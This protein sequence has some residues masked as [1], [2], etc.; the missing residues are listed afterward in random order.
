M[1]VPFP[2]FLSEEGTTSII[3]AVLPERR[4]QN[5]ALTVVHHVP[6]SFDSG[7]LKLVCIRLRRANPLSWLGAKHPPWGGS[8]TSTPGSGR[9][10]RLSL[11]L[12]LSLARF[13]YIY[14]CISLSKA[15]RRARPG[16]ASS[17][18]PR[19]PLLPLTCRGCSKVRAR[20]APR[21]VLFF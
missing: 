8:M 18:S 3:Q 10:A 16:A 5:L 9:E 2:P 15:P 1:E 14:L 12:S 7:L 13:R 17:Q 19:V 21:V 4:G 6:N 20:S 11:S